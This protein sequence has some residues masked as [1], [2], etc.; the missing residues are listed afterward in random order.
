MTRKKCKLLS[1]YMKDAF[2]FQNNSVSL[3]DFN[4]SQKIDIIVIGSGMGGLTAAALLAKTGKQVLVLEQHDRAGGYVHGFQRKKYFFDAGVHLISGCGLEG[5]SGGQII[6][7]VL[8]AID[9]YDQLEFVE[10]NPFTFISTTHHS[11]ELPLSIEGVVRQL[12]ELFP[13]QQQGLHDL[14]LL[15]LRLA[16]QLALADDV[17]ATKDDGLMYAKLDLLLKY[18]RSTLGDVWGD[19][20]QDPELQCIFAALWP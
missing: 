15:C 7:K 12:G 19:Y 5:F 10:V 14:L 17:L 2:L 20:I 18:R 16:E 13:E 9:M 8:Q 11:V 1:A 6:R 4:F 3:Q